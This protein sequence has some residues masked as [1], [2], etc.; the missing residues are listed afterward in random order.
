MLCWME[1]FLY[2]ACRKFC[3]TDVDSVTYNARTCT[4]SILRRGITEWVYQR[5]FGCTRKCTTCPGS[6]YNPG[7]TSRST[8]GEYGRSH[9]S[10]KRTCTSNGSDTTPVVQSVTIHV[11]QEAM[12][13]YRQRGRHAVTC[14]QPGVPAKQATLGSGHTHHS[15][16]AT[17]D[18]ESSALLTPAHVFHEKF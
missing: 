13:A 17:T 8:P 9:V 6:Y 14:S 3:L 7:G 5:W 16:S 11:V 4:L 18:R 12:C 2:A 1:S 10:C 15:R